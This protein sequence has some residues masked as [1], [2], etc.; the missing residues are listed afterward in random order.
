ME[1]IIVSWSSGKDSALALYYILQ[2]KN[3]DVRSLITTIT[4]EYDRV[5]MHGIRRKLL[6]KQIKSISLPIH[7][8]PLPKNISDNEYGEIMEKEMKYFKSLFNFSVV[9]GDLF[10][11]DIRNYRE[12]ALSKLDIKAIFPLW[13]T[14][15]KQLAKTFLNLG[16][17]AIITCVDS[18]ALDRS[19]VGRL[20]DNE[21]LAALPSNVDQCGENGEFHTFVFDGPIFSH[22]IRFKKG[23][24][25]FR[26]NR[27]Y[28]VD[29][30]P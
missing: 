3:Y 27:F 4:S 24:I 11:E 26:E 15:T 28:F 7:I 30:V 2:E 25:V 19:F 12:K 1:N 21:F 5:S 17:K 20:F 8:I 10:L 13:G 6:L 9:F 22:P 29:L 18:R 23:K 16:F 14:N